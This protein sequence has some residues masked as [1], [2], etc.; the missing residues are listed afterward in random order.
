MSELPT[1]L[2][3][4]PQLG[5]WLAILPAGRVEVRSGKVELGQGITTALAQ[6]VAEELDVALDRI[7]MVRASTE[8]SPNEG[9]TSGSLSVQDSG[10]ALRQVCA[11]ARDIYLHAAAK[12]LEVA[13]EDLVVEDGEIRVRGVPG[14]RTSYWELADPVHL[15]CAANGRASPKPAQPEAASAPRIDL[16]G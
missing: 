7:A 15:Q 11:E 16:P 13:P 2:K 3:A 12:R 4:N 1:S 5:Q 8:G 9:F 6:V 14:V 10:S